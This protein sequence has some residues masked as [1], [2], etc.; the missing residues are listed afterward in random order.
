MD[1]H[2]SEYFNI[3]RLQFEKSLL[4]EFL[5]RT[6]DSVGVFFRGEQSLSRNLYVSFNALLIILIEL[7]FFSLVNP[8]NTKL[9][10]PASGIGRVGG[11]GKMIELH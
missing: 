7:F 4:S 1:I 2:F 6:V 11:A 9:G 10:A 3:H 8:F 5:H